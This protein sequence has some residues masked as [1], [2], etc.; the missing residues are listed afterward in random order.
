[1]GH[2]NGA[3]FGNGSAMDLGDS[4]SGCGGG[5]SYGT[6][7]SRPPSWWFTFPADPRWQM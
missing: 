3:S 5:A 1:M 4:G 2:S 7:G 6:D